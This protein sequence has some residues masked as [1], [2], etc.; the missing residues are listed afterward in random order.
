MQMSVAEML[1]FPGLEGCHV[2]AGQTG[3]G[4]LTSK[5]N[6]VDVPDIH[7]WI[8]GGE[9]LITTAYF[10]KDNPSELA[11]LIRRVNAV[12]AAALGIKLLRFID[13]VPAEVIRVAN[14]LD[15]PLIALP[16]EAAFVDIINTVLTSIVNQQAKRLELSEQIHRA[17]TQQALL[18]GSTQEIIDTLGQIV[19]ERVVLLDT[20][21]GGCYTSAN[22][23]CLLTQESTAQLLACCAHEIVAIDQT[24]YGYLLLPDRAP[25][26][27]LED[28]LRIA[29]EH[30]ST[31]LKLGIQK[32]ISNLEIESRYRDLFLQDLI[33]NNI[34]SEEELK[35]RAGAFGWTI[36]SGMVAVSVD[37]D[38]FKSRY[39]QLADQAEHGESIEEIRRGIFRLSRHI[40]SQHFR[41]AFYTS[42]SDSIIFLLSDHHRQSVGCFLRLVKQVGDSIRAAVMQETDFTVMIGI[43]NYQ[44]D[45]LEVHRSY[46]EAKE[47]V[48]L[49]RIVYRQNST[50]L[51][52]KLGVYR[53][54]ASLYQCNEARDFMH[55]VLGKLLLYDEQHGAQL[56][57]TLEV[58]VAC[59]WNLRAA[60]SQLFVHHNT[61]K[62]RLGRIYDL[63]E[64]DPD[65]TEYKL[66]IA[67]ALRLRQMGC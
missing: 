1:Q 19:N 15:F 24:V 50:V 18:G 25:Q 65:Q 7:K 10:A 32:K 43:G 26:E 42:F 12:G 27:E 62:Y 14:E 17:F 52:D 5:V 54:L 11:D 45:A 22:G 31:V 57:P 9:F 60:A 21:F 44:Q 20:Y 34:R 55:S 29:L 3:L 46:H 28:L 59:D 13:D 4:R 41:P 23:D 38:N 67:L 56:V 51:Y 33:F 36:T 48:R 39:L 63:L 35:M 16:P 2:L 49:G 66:R 64:L 6:V 58:I 37:I 30:A 8:R 53:L 40:V 47:A 61:V